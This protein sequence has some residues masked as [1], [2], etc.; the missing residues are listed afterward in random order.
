ML[1][2]VMLAATSGCPSPGPAAAQGEMEMSEQD[3]R[4]ADERSRVLAG[5]APGVVVSVRMGV[6]GFRSGEITLTVGGDGAVRVVQRKTAG[7]R[8]YE[9]T[10]PRERLDAFGAELA[11]LGFCGLAAIPGG[12]KPGDTPMRIA[13]MKDGEALCEAALWHGD[14]YKDPALDALIKR[15]D[16]VVSELSGGVLPF[17]RPAP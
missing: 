6:E 7:E 8:T 10:W 1:W 11:G 14:R 4:P 15:Y 17:E 12:R 13:L 3:P 9:A 16:A 5:L 2:L